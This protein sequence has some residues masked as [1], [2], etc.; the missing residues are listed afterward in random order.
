MKKLHN[1]PLVLRF[2]IILLLIIIAFSVI[3][4]H[5][6]GTI[7]NC[8]HACSILL[9]NTI[10]TQNLAERARADFYNIT[11]IAESMIVNLYIGDHDAAESLFDSFNVSSETLGRDFDAIISSIE[12]DPFM[13]KSVISDFLGKMSAVKK[14]MTEEY[15]PGIAAIYS[16]IKADRDSDVFWGMK[17]AA[18]R[19]A[20]IA[21]GV[22]SVADGVEIAGKDA[23]DNYVVYLLARIGWL[24]NFIFGAIVISLALLFPLI[25]LIRKPIKDA[26]YVLQQ[27]KEGNFLDMRTPYKNEIAI[28]LN[29]VA[30]IIDSYKQTIDEKEAMRV[31]AVKANESKSRFLATMSHEI[32]TPM[33][34][35][36]GISEIE[37]MRGDLPSYLADALAKIRNSGHILLDI[38]NDILDLS[39]IET[40][41]LELVP[42]EYCLP[43]LIND[44]VQLTVIRI[45][46]KPIEFTLDVEPSVPARLHGDVLRIKQIL[47][48]I[49][50]NA[51]KYT[52]RGKVALAVSFAH[53]GVNG[54][55][56]LIFRVSDTGQGMRKEDVE[57]LFDE[58]SRFNLDVNRNTEGTGLGMTITRKLTA[59]MN[60]A[61]EVES[62]YGKGSVFTVSLPQRTVENAGIIGE[63]IARQLRGFTFSND[64]LDKKLQFQREYMPY[65]SVLIVDDMEINLFIAQGLMT[66]YGL[67]IETAASGFTAL[68]RVRAG[69]VYDVIFLDHMMPDMDGIETI[70]RL[71]E[72][73]YNAPIIAL[74]ANATMGNDKMFREH[75]FDDFISKPIDLRQL[76][77]AL[78]TYVRRRRAQDAQHQRDSGTAIEM[79]GL[80]EMTEWTPLGKREKAESAAEQAPALQNAGFWIEGVDT[81]R[82]KAMTGGSEA[83]YIEVLTLFCKDAGARLEILREIPDESSLPLFITQVHALKSASASI[84]ADEISRMAA[85]LEEAGEHGNVDLIRETLAAFGENLSGLVGRIRFHLAEC[86]HSNENGAGA[87]KLGSVYQETG[88]RLKAALLAENVGEA[89]ALLEELEAMPTSLKTKKTLSEVAGLVLTS[90]FEAAA[91][92]IDDLIKEGLR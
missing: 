34:A 28:L 84:G 17:N 31:E 53:R 56:L 78:N 38:I 27:V 83:N 70:H 73:G 36:I 87:E 5:A 76:D 24:R 35:V 3:S 81:A 30:D 64:G 10:K 26:R 69:S 88:L 45:G 46:S 72:L 6:V 29:S 55:E 49:L 66:P 12:K 8:H 77:A 22:M 59:M 44:T 85:E 25:A 42:A 65:G 67:K 14:M 48:N 75:G 80:D 40:G 13:D 21:E 9:E 11:Q 20:G 58:Y 74:T 91:N 23:Y 43:S 16:A 89:D 52:E 2:I 19:K 68:D 60:G 1:I 18:S 4:F 61:I 54:D 82:G 37:L 51:F 92:M 47:N 71:R 79:T 41:K 57:R 33:N 90:E 50:S 32:R 7:V 62:E 86:A 39:K 63:E 15:L